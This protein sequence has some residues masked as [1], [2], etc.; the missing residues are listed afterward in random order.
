MERLFYQVYAFMLMVDSEGI[1]SLC[2]Q[3][4]I[5]TLTCAGHSKRCFSLKLVYTGRDKI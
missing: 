3:I 5:F 2:I 1:Y 4:H